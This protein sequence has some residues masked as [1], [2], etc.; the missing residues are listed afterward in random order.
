ML[1]DDRFPQVEII[2]GGKQASRPKEIIDV[3]NF[4]AVKGIKARGKRISNYEVEKTDF[5]EPLQKEI[6]A[7][8][9]D[10]DIEPD[11][12]DQDETPD[13]IEFEIID[14]TSIEEETVTRD[15]PKPKKAKPSTKPAKSDSSK[16]KEPESDPKQMSLDF[17]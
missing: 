11:E 15:L 17:E 8:N 2:F 10:S 6:P 7:E 4:I 12:F 1:S 16:D 14:T 5:I 3:D 13:E 9:L